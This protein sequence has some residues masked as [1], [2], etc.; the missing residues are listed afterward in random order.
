[1]KMFCRKCDDF[2]YHDFRRLPPCGRCRGK[3]SPVRVFLI[4]AGCILAF[5]AMVCHLA[6]WV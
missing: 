6:G 5:A 2:T 1:M 4:Q 3:G